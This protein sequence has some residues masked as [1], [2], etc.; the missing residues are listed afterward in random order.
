MGLEIISNSRILKFKILG[1]LVKSKSLTLLNY[2]NKVFGFQSLK[3]K[4]SHP[5][6]P[7]RNS[8]YLW[9]SILFGVLS[10]LNYINLQ[11]L[12]IS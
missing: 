11:F 6:T 12:L 2:P 1:E 5:N 8:H 7:L 9:P 4:S 3:S 10:K